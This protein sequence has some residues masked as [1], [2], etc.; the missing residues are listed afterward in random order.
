MGTLLIG[1]QCILNFWTI[2]YRAFDEVNG[3]EVAWNQVQIDEVLQSP[4]GLER[5]YSEVHLLKSLKHRN[6]VKFYNSW[7]DDKNKT[8]NIITELFTSGSLR[9][10]VFLSLNLYYSSI[11]SYGEMVRW[12]FDVGIVRNTRKLT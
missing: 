2:S 3:I 4:D 5:L 12:P 11:L 1:L 7:I 8:V 10:Y 9:Q 6:I